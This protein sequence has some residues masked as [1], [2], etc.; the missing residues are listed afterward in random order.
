MQA[1]EDDDPWLPHI[2]WPDTPEGTSSMLIILQ[3]PGT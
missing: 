2:G 1:F 3:G